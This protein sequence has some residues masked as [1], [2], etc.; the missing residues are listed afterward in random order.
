MLE[1]CSFEQISQGERRVGVAIDPICGMTV[2]EASARSAERNGAKFYFCGE[3]CRRKFLAGGVAPVPHGQPAM[4]SVAPPGPLVQLGVAP[5]E[6]MSNSHSA[7]AGGPARRVKYICPMDPEVE[8]DVPGICPKCG[9]ALEPG[10]PTADEDEDP[11]L[12]DMSRRFWAALALS[13]PLVLLAMGPMVGLGAD[14]WLGARAQAWLQL[15][16][17]TPVVLWAGWPFFERGWRSIINRRLNMF[18]LIALGAGA[19]YL[20]SVV[21]TLFPDSLPSGLRHEGRAEVYF[22]AAAVIITLVLMGQ[23]LELR[24]AAA[25]APPFA[26]CSRWPRRWRIGW[27]MG[28]K[29]TRRPPGFAWAMCCECGPAK[30]FRSMAWWSKVAARSMSRC[31]PASRCRWKNG[32]AN[33]SSAV[34]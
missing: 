8:S 34:R 12:R 18:T 27:S 14:R 23:V 11:E 30:R 26:S 3:S 15:A 33:R 24:A 9:M 2:D 6:P 1:R 32:P 19:A 16:L 20:Y 10:F 17:A 7:P 5:R 29:R 25:P 13:I 22:E 28:K 31:S 4:R 21:A